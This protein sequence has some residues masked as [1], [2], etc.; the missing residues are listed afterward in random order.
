MKPLSIELEQFGAY[1]KHTVD[2]EPFRDEGLFLIHGDTGSGKS[3][4]LDA[5]SFALYGRGLGARSAE[6]LLRNRAAPKDGATRAALTFALGDK[7]FRVERVMEHERVRKG[8][9][10]RQRAEATL[11]CLHGDASFEPVTN[12]RK[13]TAA[14]E[15]LLGMP[16]EQFAR[17]IVLPQGE[18]RDLLLARAEDRERLLEQLF[19]DAVY[20]GV[21]ERLR[22]MDQ[23]VRDAETRAR[24]GVASRLQTTG[25]ADLDAL[26]ARRASM[27]DDLARAREAV[28]A[29]AAEAAAVTERARHARAVTERRRSRAAQ[30]EALAA[31]DRAEADAGA[32]RARLDAAD[33]AARCWEAVS[34]RDRARSALAAHAEALAD[35]RGR[36]DA[37]GA[38]LAQDAFN[39]ARID[40]LDHAVTAHRTR[41]ERLHLTARDAEELQR[42]RTDIARAEAD[43]ATLTAATARDADALARRRAA[44]DER[45]AEAARARREL[46]EQEPAIAARVGQIEARLEGVRQREEAARR[47]REAERVA[48]DAERKAQAARQRATSATST[49]DA[50]ER[51]MLDD[52]AA[53]LAAQLHAGDP[54]PVCGSD[55]HP[56][57]AAPRAGAVDRDAVLRARQA[58]DQAADALSRVESD[59]ARAE[60]ELAAVRAQHDELRRRDDAEEH[61]L[62]A[63]LDAARD[64]LRALSRTRIAVEDIERAVST[65]SGEITRDER[66]HA[67]DLTALAT[68]RTRVETLAPRAEDLA[69]RL[70]GVEPDAVSAELAR[71]DADLAG[72]EAERESLRRQRAAL[73]QQRSARRA[74]V[75]V[76][77]RAEAEAAC[78]LEESERVLRDA[79]RDGGFDDVG[80]VEAARLPSEARASLAAR[81]DA[82]ARERARVLAALDA[83]GPDEDDAGDPDALD[84]DA[85]AA[86]ARSDAARESLGALDASRA[87]LDA[88]AA[89]VEAVAARIDAESPRWRAVRSVAAAVNGRAE[90]RTRLSRFVLLDAF[91]RVV[92]CASARLEVMSDGRFHLR[93]RDIRQIG[94]EFDLLVADAYNGAAERPAA[95]LSGG[96]MFLASLAMALG[97][98]DVLQAT[99]GGVRVESLFVDEGFGALDEEALDKAVA[100]L[101][102]LRA[103]RRLVG[104]VSHV[105]ELRKRIPARL[106][107]TR[108]DHGSVTRTAIRGHLR[109]LADA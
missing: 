94:K 3:T 79:L 81:V 34:A 25:D 49:Q 70:H 28:A 5:M 58:R 108:T 21:E 95:S 52:M 60:G 88:V 100:V 107:V 96:E 18:F 85:S 90:G 46:A 7:V 50:A 71:L 15:A 53:A 17:I 43:V 2:L 83:L 63:S 30:R 27:E 48:R 72:A 89:Q 78:G 23:D 74:A 20:A 4:I 102:Q 68:A 109:P 77:E 64:A 87:Q 66:R 56:S 106:E 14:V 86:R 92:A 76:E 91:E 38:A 73:E 8:A 13:V 40:A 29:A 47:V 24:E 33:R 80:A 57:P 59:R 54:C 104:V 11:S 98:S 10:V 37:V 55:A 62:E 103:R 75:E 35:A 61:A 67:E 42:T 9:P 22:A 6:D 51:A 69:A 32:A 1:A 93:R 36:L 99:A 44:R 105:A 31:C 19:G 45:A 101:E 12:P 97:L 65:L 26:R 16:H 41:R 82:A 39:P 84:A